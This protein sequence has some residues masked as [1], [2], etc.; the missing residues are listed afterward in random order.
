MNRFIF[1]I[2]IT[3]ALASCVSGV[4]PDFP[5][6]NGNVVVNSLLVPDSVIQVQL[7]ASVRSDLPEV[8]PHINNAKV[9]VSDGDEVVLLQHQGQGIY[10]ADVHPL[11]GAEYRLKITLPDVT[12]LTALTAI[13]QKPEIYTTAFTEQN[14]VKITIADDP[15]EDNYYWVGLKS[16]TFF[17]ESTYYETY[18]SCDFP[19]F[20]D[21]NQTRSLDITGKMNFAY[22]FYA[23][24]PDTQFNGKEVSFQLPHYYSDSE[25][26]EHLPYRAY[27]YIIN[28][29]KHLDQYMKSA[30]IQYDLGVIGDMP[31]FHT[32]LD[33]Y[34][35]IENGK[36]IFGSYT[37]SQFDIT[38]PET[39]KP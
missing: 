3:I 38:V 28:A 15:M 23:R 13:P 39:A 16:F 12:P 5:E 25:D 33:I 31:V 37:I 9:E 20:D 24:L 36:G 17:G 32:P 4:D 35:N 26:Y 8:F 1:S 2:L 10:V 30:L 29:D 27:V 6:F 21:F 34:S 19:W 7:S 22:H 11:A 14:I 18:V